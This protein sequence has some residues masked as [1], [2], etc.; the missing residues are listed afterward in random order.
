LTFLLWLAG[1]VVVSLGGFALWLILSNRPPP[2][3]MASVLYQRYCKQLAKYQLKRAPHETVT[4]FA[5]RCQ[6]ALPEHANA[7]L[8]ITNLYTQARYAQDSQALQQLKQ[9]ITR[10]P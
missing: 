9:A 10:F 5:L 1:G 7:I 8:K 4:Q 3:D 2:I 6:T